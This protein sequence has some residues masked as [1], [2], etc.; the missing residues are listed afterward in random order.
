MVATN[1]PALALDAK[2]IWSIYQ[3]ISNTSST[4]SRSKLPQIFPT[5]L[6]T[7]FNFR[8]PLRILNQLD[9]TTYK[10]VIGSSPKGLCTE[11]RSDDLSAILHVID[12]AKKFIHISVS[13][14]V[15]MSLY[16]NKRQQHEWNVINDHLEY[17]IYKR[18]VEIRLLLNEHATHQYEMQ[19]HLKSFMYDVKKRRKSADIEAK[20][21]TSK[22]DKHRFHGSHSKFMVTDQ[23]GYIGT[24]NW[25]EDYFTD[26]AGTCITFQPES[27]LN[28]LVE[29]AK[30]K[31]N[32]V[33]QMEK[34]F[35]RD[36]GS[37]LSKHI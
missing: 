9:G 14:Y 36:W 13:E 30:E 33:Q 26:T 11:G 3:Y 8:K 7:Q 10:V 34:I 15:P 29:S 4:S 5:E 22:I 32:L 17:A 35:Q 1:C 16:V 24:S 25:A 19:K 2:K 21:Y 6:T 20:I 27:I 23:A 18:N 37:S 12:S 28:P 31:L